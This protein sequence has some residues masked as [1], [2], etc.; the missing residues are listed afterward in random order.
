[1]FRNLNN[2]KRSF[3]LDLNIIENVWAALQQEFW[4][5]RDSVR[6]ADEVW[7][8][9]R[10]IFHNFTLTFIRN[11]YGSLSNRIEKVIKSQAVGSCLNMA[12]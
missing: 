2:C 5:R 4:T 9:A 7:A 8:K 6:N 12:A 10:E 11:L 3:L 1:M